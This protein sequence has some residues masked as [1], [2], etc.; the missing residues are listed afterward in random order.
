MRKF[1]EMAFLA[2]LFLLYLGMSGMA[3]AKI[4]A[5]RIREKEIRDSIGR[6][7][8]MI[9]YIDS[10]LLGITEENSHWVHATKYSPTKKECG[11]GH[12]TTYDGST[13]NLRALGK[14]KLRWIAIS[15]DLLGRYKMGDTVIV[16]SPQS[17]ALNGEWIIHDLMPKR[18]KNKIDFLVPRNDKYQFHTPHKV[19]IRKKG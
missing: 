11:S 5:E 16:E 13:I 7:D 10:V 17:P 14:H 12:L 6:P 2:V 18:W 19:K 8:T 9:L 4:K 15:R 1:T 3:E